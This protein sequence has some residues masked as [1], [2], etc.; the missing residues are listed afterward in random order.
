MGFTTAA[1]VAHQRGDIIQIT[2]GCKELDTI[3]EGIVQDV[4]GCPARCHT[5]LPSRTLQ[6]LMFGFECSTGGLETGSITEIY[7]EDSGSCVDM[8][9]SAGACCGRGW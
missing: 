7:G 1:V 2:T 5:I 6:M 3:L 4:W 8:S 9:R